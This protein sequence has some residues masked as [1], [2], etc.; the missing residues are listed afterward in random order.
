M[1][2]L[3][4]IQ[5][6]EQPMRKKAD[7]ATRKW[8]SFS[9][10]IAELFNYFVFGGNK[11]IDPEKIIQLD[12]ISVLGKDNSIDE[13]IR[14]ILRQAIICTDG[15]EVMLL[16]GIESQTRID[17]KMLF[18]ILEYDLRNY[19]NSDKPIR[20][21]TL[22][23]YFDRNPW[24]A[25]T[26]LSEYCPLG[27]MVEKYMPDYFYKVFDVYQAAR[28]I[29]N[30]KNKF[31][32]ELGDYIQTCRD[33]LDGKVT[34]LALAGKYDTLSAEFITMMLQQTGYDLRSEKMIEKEKT[35]GF[36]DMDFSENRAFVR[37]QVRKELERMAEPIAQERA[38]SLAKEMAEP[39]AKERAESLA[40]EMAEEMAEDAV[41]D[42]KR[43][44]FTSL[45]AK[46]VLSDNDILDVLQIPAENREAFL[47][48]I[49]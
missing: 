36:D 28:E 17:P 20:I 14:D 31:I 30:P 9:L 10:I 45:K 43:R 48:S 41:L 7:P 37:E 38:E 15:I 44:T 35:M 8:L 2:P 13:R 39:I 25:P 40:K 24:N 12:P 16:L 3:N 26:S 6:E 21:I 4:L 34:E 27:P 18:R 49:A 1:T 22:V 29:E 42:E 5:K 47:A 11:I 32:S 23:F 33:I 46:G 19:L